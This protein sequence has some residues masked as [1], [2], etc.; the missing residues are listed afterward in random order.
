MDEARTAPGR[1]QNPS[2]ILFLAGVNDQVIPPKPTEGVIAALGNR[3]TV[4][5]YEKGY[6]MLLRDLQRELVHR[7]VA[8]R[9]V[10][11]GG[12]NVNENG[13]G[14]GSGSDSHIHALRPQRAT[15]RGVCV[16]VRACVLLWWH[17]F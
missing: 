2:P 17:I 14:S 8:A 6:H 5:R 11:L 13:P 16:C 15:D 1:L 3:A 7:D 10:L 12:G 4:K 9:N